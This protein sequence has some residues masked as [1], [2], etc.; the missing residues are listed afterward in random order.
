MSKEL[1]DYS[2][3]EKPYSAVISVLHLPVEEKDYPKYERLPALAKGREDVAVILRTHGPDA[4]R[5]L[6]I[7]CTGGVYYMEITYSMTDFGW[8]HSLLLAHD[9]LT[10]EEVGQALRSILV[11]G[12]DDIPLITEHFHE[13]SS[14]VWPDPKPDGN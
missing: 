3:R 4:I 6:R 10:A 5:E 11:E 12:T 1:T 8:P 13:I 7:T 14:R 2:R 9:S